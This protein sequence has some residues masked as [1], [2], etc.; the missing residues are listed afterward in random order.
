ME[1]NSLIIQ[2]PNTYKVDL[3]APQEA[4]GVLDLIQTVKLA[5]ESPLGLPHLPLL[6][7]TTTVA[8]A[9]NDKTRPV[10]HH[11]L[12]PPL[13]ESL[14]ASGIARENIHL[15]IATGTH[16]PMPAEEFGLVVPEELLARYSVFSHD[17]DAKDLLDLGTT[18]RGT[19]ILMNRR[20]MQADLRIVVGN[21]EPHH[22][23]GF[24]GGVKSAAIGLAGRETIVKNHS[25]LTHPLA[26]TAHYFDNPM[27][28]EVEEIGERAKVHLALNAILN[29]DK[30]IVK[31]IFGEPV[32]VMKAGIPLVQQLCQVNIKKPYDFVI[33]SAGGYPKGTSTFIKLKKHS[34]TPQ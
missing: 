2:I 28:Q 18:S 29:N 27:R 33:A 17:C 20:F 4:P 34:L 13:L 12:L 25:L 6:N 22:F 32:A 10:P 1:Q 11:Y 3:I 16:L 24:S 19:P 26:K 7:R 21:I 9:I 8:V 14:E 31:V 23:M 30:N 15:L 5:I